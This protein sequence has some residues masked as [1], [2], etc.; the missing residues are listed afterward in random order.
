MLSAIS[1]S[2]F[3]TTI[4]IIILFYYLVVA[5]LYYK[6]EI[7]SLFKTA[8]SGPH[9]FSFG[10][11]N[12][13]RPISYNELTAATGKED[14]YLSGKVHDLLEDV[15]NLLLV[16][17]KVK[18]IREEIIVALQLL[19]RNYL[20]L[21]DLPITAEINEHIIAEAKGICSITLSDAE[22]KM[23]WNG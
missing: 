2:Q 8:S 22:M 18:T 23:L 1:W 7:F 10:R 20:V 19:L 15:K 13:D 16:G 3:L 14:P 6:R 5:I 4:T 12:Q 9:A 11:E 21:K 17:A